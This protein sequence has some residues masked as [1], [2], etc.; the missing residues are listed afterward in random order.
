MSSPLKKK[1]LMVIQ[2]YPFPPR[3][4]GAIVACNHLKKLLVEHTVHLICTDVGQT[5]TEG[6]APDVGA[7]KIVVIKTKKSSRVY[8]LLFHACF[9]L[10]KTPFPMRN[11]VA[12]K[13][14]NQICKLDKEENYNSILLYGIDTTPYCPP[15]CYKKAIL[16]V[17]DPQS[18][19]NYRLAKLNVFSLF[20]KIQLV[21]YA[22]CTQFYESLFLRHFKKVHVLSRSDAEDLRLQGGYRNIGFVPYGVE[23]PPTGE[24]C[25]LKERTEG[26][27]VFSGNMFH[28]PNVDGALFLLND[29]FPLILSQYPTA[30][31]W[32]V[33]NIP[34][35][36]IYAAAARYNTSVVI[37]GGVSDISTYIKKAMVSV[38]PI[39]LKI[40]VQT[41][42]LE[43]LSWGTP[44]VTTNAGN[45]G[46]CG[47]S[48]RNL[49]VEDDPIKFADRIASFLRGDK[50]QKFSQES[51][52]FVSINYQWERSV[53]FLLSEII[54][55]DSNADVLPTID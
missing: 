29:I 5:G 33:G 6:K 36:R 41:K 54:C 20:E 31:L 48:G 35:A 16:N 38:C 1:F 43:A 34:D 27:I 30:K 8:Q 19:K 26:M 25:P 50:W 7:G 9:V 52:E 11:C 46:V 22:V 32:I 13:M 3:A 2:H 23:L 42:V 21:T 53:E 10:F 15:S 17:E 51:K 18:I 55:P 47:V 12:W 49:W 28:K 37:T 40:G 44:V 24:Y 39:R 4:G 14:R 45:S